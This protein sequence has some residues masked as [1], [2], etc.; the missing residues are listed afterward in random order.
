MACHVIAALVLLYVNVAG[1]ALLRIQQRGHFILFW[2]F[3]N[4]FLHPLVRY[5]AIDWFVRW[6]SALEARD[7]TT[8]VANDVVEHL[9]LVEALASDTAFSV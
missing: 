6:L 1:W 4:V 5:F 9:R 3:S 2:G 7:R 8:G